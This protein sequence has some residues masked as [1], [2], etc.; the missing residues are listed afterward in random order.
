MKAVSQSGA[1]KMTSFCSAEWD[2]FAA[3]KSQRTPGQYVAM[4]APKV[5]RAKLRGRARKTPAEPGAAEEMLTAA[6][7]NHKARIIV[8]PSNFFLVFG[9]ATVYVHMNTIRAA[10]GR[11]QQRQKRCYCGYPIGAERFVSS[12]KT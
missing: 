12:S 1:R 11:K 6:P 5:A 2:P 9:R 10:P 3:R 4:N 7:M 8:P